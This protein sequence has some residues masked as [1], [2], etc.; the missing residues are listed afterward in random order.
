MMSLLVLVL[1]LHGTA[2]AQETSLD[3]LARA[4]EWLRLGDQERAA[5]AFGRH[6]DLYPNSAEAA[7]A[8]LGLMR[9]YYQWN[10]IPQALFHASR[11]SDLAT[12]S[13]V[14]LQALIWQATLLELQGELDRAAATWARALQLPGGEDPQLRLRLLR[15]RA[16]RED[17]EEV[18]RYLHGFSLPAGNPES[19]LLDF[20][21][22]REA[23]AR[24]D[25]NTAT[26][27]LNRLEQS[28]PEE[29]RSLVHWH[30]LELE[31]IR[32][33]TEREAILWKML[34]LGLEE[35]ETA[36]LVRLQSVVGRQR[37]AMDTLTR[38]VEALEKQRPDLAAQLW[39]A[40]AL[41]VSD[42]GLTE[43]YLAR[44]WALHDR[45]E[46][47][48]AVAVHYARLLSFR[49]PD[50]AA[51][52]LGQ[53]P[54][55]I[56]VVEARRQIEAQ[57]QRPAAALELGERLLREY[58]DHPS[59]PRWLL[60]QGVLALQAGQPQRALEYRRLVPPAEANSE[61]W[62][63]ITVAALKAL[64]RAEEAHSLWLQLAQQS[65]RPRDAIDALQSALSL[66]RWEE[67]RRMLDEWGRSEAFRVPPYS[68]EV[69]FWRGMLSLVQGNVAEAERWWANLP[70]EEEFSRET[71]PISLFYRAWLDLNRERPQP[72]EALRRL[73]T[74]KRLHS[75]H[76]LAARADL[77]RARASILLGNQ[78]QAVEILRQIT[79]PDRSRALMDLSD[80]LL[81][82]GR[83]EEARQALLTLEREFP[84]REVQARR[85]LLDIDTTSAERP[86]ALR[87]FFERYPTSPEGRLALFE[88]SS[89]AFGQGQ[90]ALA[91]EW[92]TEFVRKQ[93]GHEQIGA[94]AAIGARAWSRLGR[95]EEGLLVL[96]LAEAQIRDPSARAELLLA[97][98]EIQLATDRLEEAQQSLA[99]VERLKGAGTVQPIL[100]LI[101]LRRQGYD[102][103]QARLLQQLETLPPQSPEAIE[104]RLSLIGALLRQ[105]AVRERELERH[106]QAALK[107]EGES[108]T[109]A[110][111]L[112]GRFEEARG[113][114]DRAVENYLAAARSPQARRLTAAEALYRA[115]ALLRELSPDQAPRVLQTLQTR[116]G[117][118]EWARKALEEGRP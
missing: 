60:G 97:K 67:A 38:R 89:E 29:V 62:L 65:G 73:N 24:S 25:F 115:W 30:R 43:Q 8:H 5:W 2:I 9:I 109:R 99:E 49:D 19:V 23:L 78:A 57:R 71:R 59:R 77:L 98:A 110:W 17:W 33:P 114:Q 90:W 21:R 92:A 101:R 72:E 103:E 111:L 113:N 46:V 18:R 75:T 27:V 4:E 55:T 20:I 91:A 79:G 82:L 61:P 84:A 53:A 96:G 31:L 26:E 34:D 118:T 51:T 80:V 87:R 105:A 64:G 3:L 68:Q 88:A 13:S 100:T 116:Y 83:R 106:L 41:G 63:R 112:Q 6:L 66:N 42:E 69:R 47:S 28:A 40:L 102:E 95:P 36:A 14:Q 86:G 93:P 44:A 10:E 94:A 22:L 85:R 107:A 48:P 11:A 1:I 45:T 16:L 117:D 35:A 74:L 81:S 39:I 12:H 70:A 76:P 58:P 54:S 104:V 50:R 108:L 37:A 52:V 32:N 7:R 15:N 56:E